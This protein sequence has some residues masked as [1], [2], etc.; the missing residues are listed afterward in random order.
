MP[1]LI[2]RGPNAT[3]VMMGERAADLMA[4]DPVVVPRATAS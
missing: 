4:A 2:R 1:H 3:A